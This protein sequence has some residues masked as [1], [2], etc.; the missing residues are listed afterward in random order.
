MILFLSLIFSF[1]TF[2]QEPLHWS[3]MLEVKERHEFYQN[4]EEIIKPINSWQ[5]LFAVGYVDQNFKKLKDCVFYKVPGDEKGTLKLRTIP[6]TEKCDDFLLST[7]DKEISNIKSLQFSITDLRL[8]IEFTREDYKSEK[9]VSK[10]QNTFVR[11]EPKLNLSSVDY[12]SPKITLLAPASKVVSPR[13]QI[14]KDK[15]LCHDVNED[16][17]EVSGSTC[18]MCPRGWYEIPNGCAQGPKYCG[19]QNCGGKDEPACRRGIKWQKS[20]SELD[21]RTDKSF[22]YCSKGLN[23]T[24][25]GR[26]AF[27]H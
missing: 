1:T 21:C 7:G 20:P 3:Y 19:I 4:N 26:K 18:H 14:L 25:E 27:C 15:T 6:D 16:C 9:W 13:P 22:V 2:A 10:T 17:E 23:V 11:P 5:L 8:S 24:C 12:K